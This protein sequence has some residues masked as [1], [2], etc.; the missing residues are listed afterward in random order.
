MASSTAHPAPPGFVVEQVHPPQLLVLH[1]NSFVPAAWRARLGG[2][3]DFSWTWTFALADTARAAPACCGSW[4][5]TGP[6][7]L[8][9]AYLAALVP[10]D[11]VL[12]DSMLAGVRRRADRHDDAGRPGRW[13]RRHRR[14]RPDRRVTALTCCDGC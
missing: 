3:I 5:R 7:W 14:Q 6:W 10:A 13:W 11:D 1:S 4:A 9:V 2:L 8:S 12:A